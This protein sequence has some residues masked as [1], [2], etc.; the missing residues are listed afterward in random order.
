MISFWPGPNPSPEKFV[1]IPDISG[2]VSEWWLRVES[3]PKSGARPSKR[4]V[5]DQQQPSMVKLERLSECSEKGLGKGNGVFRKRLVSI[6]P[7]FHRAHLCFTPFTPLP[8][9]NEIKA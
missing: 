5:T 1:D 9:K 4:E 8:E 3:R 2:Q 7:F 6:C